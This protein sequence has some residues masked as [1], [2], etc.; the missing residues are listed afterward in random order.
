MEYF[1]LKL[2]QDLRNRAAHPHQEFRGVPALLPSPG[3]CRKRPVHLKSPSVY[4]TF[5][6]HVLQ[7]LLCNELVT[8]HVHQKVPE[9]TEAESVVILQLEIN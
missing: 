1:G 8:M 2:G 5:Y 9:W 6:I 4:Q 3:L 7:T